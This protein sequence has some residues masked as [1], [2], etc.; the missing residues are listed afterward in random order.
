ML[1]DGKCLCLR[2]SGWLSF[3][4]QGACYGCALGLRRASWHWAFPQQID[5][6]QFLLS[7]S[8]SPS[9]AKH[10]IL[11]Q[12]RVLLGGSLNGDGQDYVFYCY[13]RR[14]KL[15]SAVMSHDVRR[16]ITSRAPATPR[17]T[18]VG[19]LGTSK[20]NVSHTSISA[21]TMFPHHQARYSTGVW[22][23]GTPMR[24]G[25]RHDR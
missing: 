23:S 16:L 9:S 11:E 14:T 17:G 7:R 20:Y 22:M 4:R 25:V 2:A 21:A 10:H 3:R 12:I 15:A 24:P 19:C 13:D 18:S 6:S 1:V 5:P 8:P